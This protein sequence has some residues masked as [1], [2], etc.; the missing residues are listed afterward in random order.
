MQ[1]HKIKRIENE[2]KILECDAN[3]LN[4]NL[5]K[6]NEIKIYAE[7]YWSGQLSE[8]PLIEILFS[9]NFQIIE[10]KK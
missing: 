9:G 8:N 3:L 2:S 5:N 1:E 4:C 7:K 6:V 10:I